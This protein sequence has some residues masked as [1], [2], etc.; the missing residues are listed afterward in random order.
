[1]PIKGLTDKRAPTFPKI[2]DIRKGAPKPANGGIGKDLTYFRAVF[3]EGETK[4]AAKFAEIYPDEP[5]EINIF[6][7]FDDIDRNFE[8]WRERHTASALQCRGDGEMAIVWRDDKGEIQRE[9]KQCPAKPC[10]GCKETGRLKIIVPEL[11]R[12]AYL[13]VHTTSKWDIIELTANLNA[14]KKLTGDGL[15]G[16]PLVLKRRP[17]IIS[18]PRGN[19]KRVRQ[20]MWLLSIEADP[21]WVDAQLKAMEIAALPSSTAPPELPEVVDS[22]ESAIDEETGEVLGEWDE[23]TFNAGEE[24]EETEEETTPTFPPS[25]GKFVNMAA[26]QLG[27]K[28]AS[29]VGDTL[30]KGKF[31]PALCDS[32]G[33]CNFNRAEGWALLEEKAPSK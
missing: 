22:T 13:I 32:A 10:E 7:P 3:S 2:G 27:Y 28:G 24:S 31:G 33:D 12:L 16:I 29:D 4:A 11:R 15:K 20:E 25:Y 30:K 9:Y 5:R 17:R 18:T 14:L 6:L 1:M 21:R 8:A 23:E 19:G 26:T